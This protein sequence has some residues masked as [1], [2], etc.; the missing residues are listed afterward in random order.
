MN[1][2]TLGLY[3]ILFALLYLVSSFIL[4]EVEFFEQIVST[5]CFI[6]GILTMLAYRVS[7]RLRS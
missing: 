5:L 2:Y 3:F 6:I 1:G 7:I 4:P